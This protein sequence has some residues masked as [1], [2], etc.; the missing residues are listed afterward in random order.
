MKFCRKN[1]SPPEGVFFTTLPSETHDF[2]KSKKN[3][4]KKT[5][6]K[7]MKKNEKSDGVTL[8]GC[9]QEAVP[10]GGKSHRTVRDLGFFTHVL[11]APNAPGAG[12]GR[13]ARESPGMRGL[14]K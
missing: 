5:H 11:G 14:E 6:E 2:E 8:S 1:K 4:K 10:E 12:P 7:Q 13:G 3:N 9:R